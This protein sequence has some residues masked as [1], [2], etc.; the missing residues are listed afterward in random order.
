MQQREM[1]NA[2][3]VQPAAFAKLAT[4]VQTDISAWNQDLG[5][6]LNLESVSVPAVGFTEAQT[7]Q[8]NEAGTQVSKWMSDSVSASLVCLARN[9]GAVASGCA[10]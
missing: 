9:A 5:S 6:R 1:K 4:A 2:T 3:R 7:A 8:Y 10:R